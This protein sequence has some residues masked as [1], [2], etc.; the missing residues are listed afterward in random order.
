MFHYGRRVLECL[1]VHR[2]SNPT[3][4]VSDFLTLVVHHWGLF[5]FLIGYFLFNPKYTP[6]V[7]GGFTFGLCVLFYLFT[8]AMNCACHFALRSLRSSGSDPKKI[9]HVL[10][11]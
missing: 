11:A 5:G 7:Q 1:F 4:L 6:P 3:I 2:Y 9:P 10:F 8:E